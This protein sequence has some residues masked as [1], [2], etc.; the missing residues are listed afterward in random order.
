MLQKDSNQRKIEPV[1]KDGDDLVVFAG[2]NEDSRFN[3]K[4]KQAKHWYALTIIKNIENNLLNDQKNKKNPNILILGVA[5]GSLTIHL[6]NKYKHINITAVDLYDD[7]FHIVRKYTPKDRLTLIKADAKDFLKEEKKK[8]DYIVIDLFGIDYVPDFV[9]KNDFMTNIYKRL[10]TPGNMYINTKHIEHK[11]LNNVLRK[12]FKKC[13]I[14][15]IP[16]YTHK[17]EKNSTIT[18]VSCV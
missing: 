9:V 3:T 5:L 1:I 7:Y 12:S 13:S 17:T 15:N 10:N 4:T 8:Y 6:L 16:R 18:I 11:D 2:E 14:K